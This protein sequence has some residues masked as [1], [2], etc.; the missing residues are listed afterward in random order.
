MRYILG[1]LLLVLLAGGIIGCGEEKP[2]MP[3]RRAASSTPKETPKADKPADDKK[4]TP[5]A[6]T[7]SPGS[8][9]QP[10]TPAG[11]PATLPA[12]KPTTTSPAGQPT[13]A[14]KTS[15]STPATSAPTYATPE[16]AEAKSRDN[17]QMIAGAMA[18][19][20][21]KEKHFPPAVI[22]Q[23]DKPLLS[24][25]VALLPYLGQQDLYKQFNLQEPWNSPTNEPLIA[26]IPL[27]YMT[28]GRPMDGKTC[29]LV[30]SGMGT[31]FG[32]RD[33]MSQSLIGDG[34][35]KT[36]L[37][38]EADEPVTWTQPEDL[39]YFPAQPL[40]GLGTLRNN[41]FLV[42]FAN[43]TVRSLPI[44]M[45]WTFAQGLFSANGH[46]L[47]DLRMLDQ[48]ISQSSKP[49]TAE[50]KAPR[51]M[52]SKR[53]NDAIESLAKGNLKR[54]LML[55]LAEA[56][57][58]N[59]EV[60]QSMKWSKALKRPMLMVRC[61]VVVQAPGV[62]AVS[63][64]AP[65]RNP[66][67]PNVGP[68]LPPATSE[69]L[70][71]WGNDFGKPLLERLKQGIT[72]GS[73]GNWL[74]AASRPMTSAID[75]ASGKGTMQKFTNEGGVLNMNLMDGVQARRA[76]AKEGLDVLIL[77]GITTKGVKV[78]TEY[79]PQSTLTIR[80]MDV[81]KDELLW[82]SKPAN[83]SVAGADAAAVEEGAAARKRLLAEVAEYMEG[84]V[85]LTPMP[86]FTP[87]VVQRRAESIA[88]RSDDPLPILAELRYYEVSKLL[89]PE[90]LESCFTRIV[91][92]EIGRQLATG[93]DVTRQQALDKLLGVEQD[94]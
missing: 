27:I 83:S 66:R 44:K 80:V 31:I 42:A 48:M 15:T 69:A 20:H 29:Y 33:G 56:A 65:S 50:S 94:L 87:E 63:D 3:K 35:D 28:P 34:K 76:A 19:Y 38:V 17:L 85:W 93:S 79:R 64:T 81:L 13:A 41:R 36:L 16:A 67:K 72:S 40:T 47:I 86:E 92:A 58:G 37:I 9:T 68:M 45:D 25:R 12:G 90:Q 8:T 60:L 88:Q 18:A 4:A 7:A 89:T 32:Q 74:Q 43:G 52:P 82:T 71:Y 26:K 62:Q 91:G 75:V 6:S 11:Q 53:Q 21:Q 46:E 1:S 23:G 54:G 57:R 59:P 5:P 22:Y 55:L 78:K 70:T 10:T 2:T 51:V 30:P 49:T 73:M 24:W 77:A 84:N 39:R 14:P 61:G